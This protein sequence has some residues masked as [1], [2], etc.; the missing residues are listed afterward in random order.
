MKKIQKNIL[1]ILLL[2]VVFQ[3]SASSI[4]AQDIYINPSEVPNNTR[5]IT[6]RAT[7]KPV[8]QILRSI[9]TKGKFNLIVA[10]GFVDNITT[11]NLRKVSIKEALDSLMSLNEFSLLSSKGSVIAKTVKR[12]EVTTYIVPVEHSQAIK[13]AY[14]LNK[15][16]IFKDDYSIT[17]DEFSNSIILH[18]DNDFITKTSAL[19]NKI[20]LPKKNSTFKLNNYKAS[21]AA[22]LMNKKLFS[23]SATDKIS[24]EPDNVD[25]KPELNGD[26]GYIIKGIVEKSD[27][28]A[29]MSD[30]PVIIPEDKTN[31]VTVI[32]NSYQLEIAK[33]FLSYLDGK[34]IDKDEEI[35]RS[36]NEIFETKNALRD[37][38]DDLK[39]SQKRLA[40]ALSDQSKKGTEITAIKNEADKIS[41]N[42]DNFKSEKLWT[43]LLNSNIKDKELYE[44]KINTLSEN[45]NKLETEL[46]QKEKAISSMETSQK[47]L[48][49]QLEAKNNELQLAYNELAELKSKLDQRISNNNTANP[50]NNNE[51]NNSILLIAQK[52]LDTTKN[53]LS[54]VKQQ[55]NASKQQL[56]LIFGGKILKD[57]VVPNNKSAWF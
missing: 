38:M 35:R 51:N 40:E 1:S 43:D 4:I 57:E 39:E 41:S 33:E 10:P 37:V 42:I 36:H 23:T 53:E 44:Q 22:D 49:K 5:V 16:T 56:E 12:S 31:E 24:N 8:S 34:N 6:L 2:L 14:S 47:E 11:L 9:A 55:L 32:G 7:N 25:L 27:Y 54:K 19:I 28:N 3:F 45:I 29:I 30:N 15:S 21:Q 52:E 13:I 46:S 17:Y 20:D 50:A 18:G 26:A 48:Y